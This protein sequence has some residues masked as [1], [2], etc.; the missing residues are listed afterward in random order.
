[1]A[2]TYTQRLISSAFAF[3]KDATYV[4]EM[5]AAIG[6]SIGVDALDLAANFN[7][8]FYNSSTSSYGSGFQMEQVM[9]LLLDLV[10]SEAAPSV[11]AQLVH[12][13]AHVHKN[14]SSTGIVG[15][16]ATWETLPKI[17]RADLGLVSGS[18]HRSTNLNVLSRSLAE[19]LLQLQP[20]I[21]MHYVCARACFVYV[22]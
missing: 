2:I 11:I 6:E 18:A 15:L 1:M 12:D 9:P 22:I 3:V 8:S 14:H 17:G 19:P 13:I 20:V 4:T 21:C 10:S 7:A 16:Q 5:G